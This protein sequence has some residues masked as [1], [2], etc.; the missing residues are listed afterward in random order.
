MQTTESKTNDL[1]ERAKQLAMAK[2]HSIESTQTSPVGYHSAGR[3]LI[4]GSVE[5]A[6]PL[7]KQLQ[8]HLQCTVV[9]IQDSKA[10][11]ISID[12]SSG[13]LRVVNA[14]GIE[15]DGY[16]GSFTVFCTEPD[17]QHNLAQ[18]L[19]EQ[20]GVFDLV[21]DL[22]T[23]PSISRDVLPP[24]YYAPGD[25]QDN[26]NTILQELPGLVGEFEKPKY[27]QYNPDICAH[28]AS[29]I[30]GCTR[31]IDACPTE[32]IVSL[33]EKVE[34][35][36]YLCQG[37]GSCATV[38]PSGAMTFVYPPLSETLNNVRTLARHYRESGG[39]EPVL[40]FHDAMAGRH[41][42]EPVHEKIPGNIIPMEIEE[43]GA[44]G[45]EVWLAAMAYGI[46][47]TVLLIPPLTPGRV[48]QAI[49]QQ[50]IYASAVIEGV[51]YSPE[52]ISTISATDSDSLMDQLNS[53][54]VEADIH[55]ATFSPEYD[56]R[57]TLRL[58]M[59]HLYR[60]APSQVKTAP[61]PSGAPFGEIA[62]EKEACTLCLAC[63][64]VCP[65]SAL[66]DGQDIPQLRFD[67]W[68]CVQCGLCEKACPEE[69][70]TRNARFVYDPEIRRRT[71]ILNEDVPFCCVVC[72]KPF[73]TNA[74][75]QTISARLKNHYMFQTPESKR[76][77]QMCEDC[78]VRDMFKQE[79]DDSTPRRSL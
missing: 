66:A 28:G 67:E 60:H 59:D 77:L 73:A 69:A 65:T 9:Q 42:L 33:G 78:R 16:L 58:A 61:L 2:A 32:A 17:E 31:C 11:S 47:K 40:L 79:K 25:N 19:G 57:T 23:S 51:G 48:Q 39:R 54:Q 35:N 62:V 46:N 5:K 72:G 37:G 18:M 15:I 55:P 30:N 74:V 75:M 68:N 44:V 50:M 8:K 64:S 13:K 34:V 26:L 53:M 56:K 3:L 27:F 21:L 52:Y 70:I 43:I 1:N 6:V 36:P 71:R 76:R 12:N 38:C 22:E 24:G 14:R 29:G 20:D 4:V 10:D 63:V 7:A 45:I 41:I 49:H